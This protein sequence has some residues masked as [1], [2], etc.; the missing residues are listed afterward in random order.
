MKTIKYIL[1]SAAVIFFA[2]NIQSCKYNIFGAPT[3]VKQNGYITDTLGNGISNV[4]LD[5]LKAEEFF[6]KTEKTDYV[7]Y[8]DK[9]GHYEIYIDNNDYIYY[10]DMTHPDYIYPVRN[11]S[12][13]PQTSRGESVEERNY[14]MV[15]KGPVKIKGDIR[16][17]SPDLTYWLD[18]VKV[19]VLKRPVGNTNYPDNT[20]IYAYT[21]EN[22][23]FYLEYPEDKNYEFFLKP[24]KE[25]YYYDGGY[26]F[27]DCS[28]AKN[29]DP[30]YVISWGFEMKKTGE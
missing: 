1:F 9:N 26:Y 30:G 14:Q 13:Y 22:G 28:K 29:Y 24:E 10:I 11:N 21:N 20:G 25:G 4:R 15:K 12:P 7:F 19:S 17:V 5:T 18:S 3:F 2:V 23:I 8:T 16:Y 6:G 27:E